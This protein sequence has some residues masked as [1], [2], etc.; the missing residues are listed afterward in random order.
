MQSRGD[1]R[2]GR[3]RVQ[4]GR[5]VSVERKRK[6]NQDEYSLVPGATIQTTTNRA[7]MERSASKGPAGQ[8]GFYLLDYAF[9]EAISWHCIDPHVPNA[10]NL[11]NYFILPTVGSID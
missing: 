1:L 10:V 3:V 5:E 2:R 7:R 6:Y 4:E 11:N 9:A 8:V